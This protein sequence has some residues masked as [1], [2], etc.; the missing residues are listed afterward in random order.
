MYQ[1]ALDLPIALPLTIPPTLCLNAAE[2][3]FATYTSI[4]HRP[5]PTRYPAATT[6]AHTTAPSRGAAPGDPP[7]PF[8]P[9]PVCPVC[10][11][12]DEVVVTAGAAD[13]SACLRTR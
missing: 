9:F 2:P 7:L 11:G 1:N 10:S 12:P 3:C 8:V 5:V 4:L 6:A 13:K